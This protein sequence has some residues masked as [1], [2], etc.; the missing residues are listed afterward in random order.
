MQ[1]RAE[2]IMVIVPSSGSPSVPSIVW[3][4]RGARPAGSANLRAKWPTTRL[5]S[6]EFY[7]APRLVGVRFGRFGRWWD[8]KLGKIPFNCFRET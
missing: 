7:G 6:A 8:V 4:V 2:S 5:E 3:V 1:L